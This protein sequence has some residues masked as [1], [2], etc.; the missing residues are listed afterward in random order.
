[1][2]PPQPCLMSNI[3]LLRCLGLT[4]SSASYRTLQFGYKKKRWKMAIKKPTIWITLP[5]SLLR[6]LPLKAWSSRRMDAAI[7]L[8]TLKLSHPEHRGV[9]E[10]R[11]PGDLCAFPLK[12][13]LNA[14]GRLLFSHLHTDTVYMWA[15]MHEWIHTPSHHAIYPP[16][17]LP[18]LKAFEK[19]TELLTFDSDT[20]LVS[21]HCC[22]LYIYFI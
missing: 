9:V 16:A 6:C 17:Y 18:L 19:R 14:A 12:V 21:S 5:I 3:I 2:K 13:S 15:C 20:I 8:G 22:T 7:Y 10:I 4:G 1:M 11:A